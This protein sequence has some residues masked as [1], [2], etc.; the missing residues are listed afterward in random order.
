MFDSVKGFF[1]KKPIVFDTSD[2]IT[3]EVNEKGHSVDENII[4]DVTDA[5]KEQMPYQ[6]K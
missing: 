2:S 3:G 4:D 6:L 5:N 1:P